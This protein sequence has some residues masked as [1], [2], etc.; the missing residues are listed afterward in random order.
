MYGTCGLLSSPVVLSIRLLSNSP[1]AAS[2]TLDTSVVRRGYLRPRDVAKVHGQS[3]M[4]GQSVATQYMNCKADSMGTRFNNAVLRI[5]GKQE[6]RLQQTD[7]RAQ[8]RSI[9]VGLID[10][11]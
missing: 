5:R 6:R 3:K 1:P 10:D 8:Q 2:F 11:M 7:V 4:A 9:H